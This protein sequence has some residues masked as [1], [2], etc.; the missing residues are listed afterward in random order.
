[1][2]SNQ[3]KKTKHIPFI[4]LFIIISSQAVEIRIRFVVR[5]IKLEQKPNPVQSVLLI[6]CRS[7]LCTNHINILL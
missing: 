5:V 3:K 1:M 7:F 2:N 6:S 4:C